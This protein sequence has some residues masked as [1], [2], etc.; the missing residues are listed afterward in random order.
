M[1]N[2]D[3]THILHPAN[4]KAF[5]DSFLDLYRTNGEHFNRA[6]EKSSKQKRTVKLAIVIDKSNGM[7]VFESTISMVTA[8]P[9]RDHRRVTAEDPDQLAIPFEKQE[10]VK[11][12]EVINPKK[13][14]KKAKK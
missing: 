4:E 3:K 6:V 9:L 5:I 11:P 2:Y 1:S 14:A 10:A 7:P 12:L 8:D 13:K